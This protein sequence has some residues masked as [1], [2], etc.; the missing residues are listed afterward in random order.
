MKVKQVFLLLSLILLSCMRHP[1]PADTLV[2]VYSDTT[3][4]GW[5][6][7]KSDTAYEVKID[8]CSIKWN[9]IE[10][11]DSEGLL[12]LEMRRTCLKSF[13]EQLPIHEAILKEIFTGYDKELFR[14]LSWGSF[15]HYYD[16]SWQIPIVLASLDSELYADYKEHYPNSEITYLNDLFVQ[17][18]NETQAYAGLSTLFEIFDLKIQLTSVEKVFAQRVDDLPFADALRAKG[19]KGNPRAIYDVGMSYFEITSLKEP[20]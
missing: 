5:A 13:E 6:F 9:V 14:S 4:A 17:L 11:K 16:H 3:S 20:N 18:A 19:V 12:D 15:E 10:L 2:K 1:E 8:D 7:K